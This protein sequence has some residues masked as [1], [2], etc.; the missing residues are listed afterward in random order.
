[1]CPCVEPFRDLLVTKR[2]MESGIA[3][4]YII[5]A[6]ISYR[7]AMSTDATGQGRSVGR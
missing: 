4:R 6:T 3:D 1:M 2:S 7:Q 5:E